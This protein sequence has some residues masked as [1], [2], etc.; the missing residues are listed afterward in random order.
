MLIDYYEYDLE[1]VDLRVIS[2]SILF[3][4]NRIAV[5]F[6]TYLYTHAISVPHQPKV[7][8]KMSSAIRILS[9]DTYLRIY[10]YDSRVYSIIRM[11]NF[12]TLI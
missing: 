7:K 12:Q 9:N 5:F 4:D 10:L 3:A 11:R 6:Y 8:R 2:S 1:N